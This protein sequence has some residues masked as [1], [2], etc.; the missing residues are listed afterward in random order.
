MAKSTSNDARIHLS[1]NVML[2]GPDKPGQSPTL[3]IT[4][5]DFPNEKVIEPL[6]GDDQQLVDLDAVIEEY[7]ND[8]FV[9]EEEKAAVAAFFRGMAELLERAKG[10]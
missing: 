4:Q 1:L 7:A 9:D 10:N 2:L 3:S 6:R 8:A 5:R